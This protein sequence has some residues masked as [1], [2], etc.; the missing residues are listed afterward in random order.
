[1]EITALLDIILKNLKESVPIKFV[2]KNWISNKKVDDKI[3]YTAF[4]N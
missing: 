2:I 4:N 1:M 3:S